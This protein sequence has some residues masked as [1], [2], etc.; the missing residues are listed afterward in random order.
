MLIPVHFLA[1]C[2]K[3]HIDRLLFH[4]YPFQTSNQLHCRKPMSFKSKLRCPHQDWRPFASVI[5]R[6]VLQ[7]GLQETFAI[8]PQLSSQEP[9]EE[10]TKWLE[11]EFTDRKVR[12][13]NLPSASRLPL[14]GLEQ[15]GSI[16]ALVLPSDGLTARHRKGVTVERFFVLIRD[17]LQS[18]TLE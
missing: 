17:C 9:G 1:L 13:S 14:S 7:G 5:S 4:Y 3:V 16:P 11:R 6:G 2:S 12:G 18:G 10:M 8:F 15:P